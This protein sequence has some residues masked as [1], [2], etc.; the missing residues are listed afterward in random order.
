MWP[1]LVKHVDS[2]KI[3]RVYRLMWSYLVIHVDILTLDEST[4]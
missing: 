2:F 4:S 1:Y 3:G